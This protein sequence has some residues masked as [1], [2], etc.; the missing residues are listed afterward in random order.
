MDK[1]LVSGAFI[2][3]AVIGEPKLFDLQAGTLT[4]I[5]WLVVVVLIARDA[6]V[7]ILRHLA[8]ARGIDFGA[9]LSGKLKMFLHTFAIGTV[10]VRN[11]SRPGRCLGIL[12]YGG[13]VRNYADSNHNILA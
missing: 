13:Y 4:I 8:E 3:F 1:I 6:Y 2:C 11:G 12:V 7:T 5:H 10:V 9:I